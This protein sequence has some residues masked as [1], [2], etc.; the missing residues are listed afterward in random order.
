MSCKTPQTLAGVCTGWL[1]CGSWECSSQQGNTAI[2]QANAVSANYRTCPRRKWAPE[3]WLY[4]WRSILN[5]HTRNVMERIA[6]VCFR[7][8]LKIQSKWKRE[9]CSLL[10]P[11][12]QLHSPSKRPNSS[13][14]HTEIVLQR[15]Q[16]FFCGSRRNPSGMKLGSLPHSTPFISAASILTSVWWLS[17]T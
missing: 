2:K 9:D 10:Q 16:V 12:G 15:C 1:C 7:L 11:A 3:E 5:M 8:Q 4:S 13:R 14:K 6:S 17:I